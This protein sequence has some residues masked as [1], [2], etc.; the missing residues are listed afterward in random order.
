MHPSQNDFELFYKNN[1]NLQSMLWWGVVC[2]AADAA[3]SA[4][5]RHLLKM[6]EL[7]PD[8]VGGGSVCG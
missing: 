4:I 7:G 1:L 2:G 6:N 8:V 5:M 3:A